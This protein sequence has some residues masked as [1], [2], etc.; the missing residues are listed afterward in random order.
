VRLSRWFVE[1]LVVLN[2]EG[3]WF[4]AWRCQGLKPPTLRCIRY[5]D[6]TTILSEENVVYVTTVNR[7]ASGSGDPPEADAFQGFFIL[8]EIRVNSCHSWLK[9]QGFPGEP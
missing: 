2:G 1:W 7:R 9:L 6:E 8:H 4:A 5:G 3:G